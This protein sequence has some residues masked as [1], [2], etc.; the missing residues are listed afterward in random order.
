MAALGGTAELRI[1]NISCHPEIEEELTACLDIWLVN[2]ISGF[3]GIMLCM[4]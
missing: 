1:G 2:V 3:G 4:G